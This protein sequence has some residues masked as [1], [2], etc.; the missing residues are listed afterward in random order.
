MFNIFSL[1]VGM[2][3]SL[4]GLSE[5]ISSENLDIVFL[6]EVR[7]TSVQIENQLPG[8]TAVSNVD[9]QNQSAPGTALVWRRDIPVEN[10]VSLKVCRMQMATLGPYKLL[11]IYAPSGS[12]LKNERELFFSQD[13]FQALQL[14]SDW[15]YI[16][17]GDFNCLLKPIDVE[18]GIG[19]SQKRV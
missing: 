2:N 16:L 7:L 13:I 18:N 12:N 5:F 15:P 10:V 3:N 14:F 6:Q 11:N 17:G 8:F 1:N 9:L 4:A 19:F